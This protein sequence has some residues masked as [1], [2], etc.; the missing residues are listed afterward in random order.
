MED[1]NRP[2]TG[3]P[4]SAHNSYPNGYAVNTNPTLSSTGYPYAAPPPTTDYYSYQNNPYNKQ[5]YNQDP[6]STRC[7]TCLHRIFAFGIGLII[8]LGIITFIVWLVLRPQLPEFRVDSF[9]LSNFIVGN[10]YET[11]SSGLGKKM[12][13]VG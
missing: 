3:Y 7:A 1:P 9:S 13:W 5:N 10:E 12:G 8:I 6:Y 11:L 2:V 4:A